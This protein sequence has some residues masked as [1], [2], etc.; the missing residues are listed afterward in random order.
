MSQCN[1]LV[2]EKTGWLTITESKSV[3]EINKMCW[4]L[5]VTTTIRILYN[6]EWTKKRETLPLPALTF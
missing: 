3:Y 6:S 4:T 2:T 5:E 1:T